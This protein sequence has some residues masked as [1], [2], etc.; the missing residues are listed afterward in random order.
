MDK[1]QEE[2]LLQHME[3]F[4]TQ[5]KG[6]EAKLKE[7][8]EADIEFRKK[9]DAVD[10]AHK[11]T[12]DLLADRSLSLPGVED[13]G[14]KVKDLDKKFIAF[15]IK[16]VCGFQPTDAEKKDP[17]WGL[18]EEILKESRRKDLAAGTGASGG[19]LIPEQFM[20]SLFVDKLRAQVALVR[21]GATV[22]N[23][24]SSPV[25]I[26]K[27]TGDVTAQY[28]NENTSITASDI[29]TAQVKATARKV[30]AMT[31]ISNDLLLLNALSAQTFVERSIL[32]QHALIRDLKGLRGDGTG[33]EPL[34]LLNV[35]GNTTTVAP[36]TNGD[37]PT[38]TFL[39]DVWGAPQDNNVPENRGAFIMHPKVRRNIIS[40]TG[41]GDRPIFNWNAELS[42]SGMEVRPTIFGN[43]VVT[44]TQ[45]PINL[46]KGSSTALSEIYYSS[47]WGDLLMA[48][49][50]SASILASN[51]S[52][53][54]FADDQT[55]IRGISRNDFAV[56]REESFAIATFV[57][58]TNPIA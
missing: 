1:S 37:D 51:L 16:Q 2:K 23:F 58:T 7:K 29:T 52:G 5:L 20:A 35:G 45:I 25:I 43:D 26:P 9:L 4:G 14:K 57:G 24:N 48:E 12:A 38:F 10:E 27:M 49:F 6:I 22:M 15:G 42:E 36:G 21:A 50:G 19:F 33:A 31:K 3:T 46:A 32:S 39:L 28:Q 30:T 13:E 53:T 56:L 47:S 41:S 17:A 40:Q 18:T 34:G 44:T 11:K 8:D 55:W 54:A